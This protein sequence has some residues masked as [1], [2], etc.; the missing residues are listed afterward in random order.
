VFLGDYEPAHSTNYI[1]WMILTVF[2]IVLIGLLIKKP[3][4]NGAVGGFQ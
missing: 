1:P 4:K 3:R 2:L